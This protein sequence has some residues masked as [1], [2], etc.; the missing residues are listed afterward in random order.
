MLTTYD[1]P[2]MYGNQIST[3]DTLRTS[4]HAD[5]TLLE[6]FCGS[7]EV[8]RAFT[9]HGFTCFKVDK[10]KRAGKCVPDLCC[11]LLKLN[12]ALFPF[13]STSII[14]A[15]V[16]CDAFS[17]AAGN[18]YRDGTGYKESTKYFQKLLIKTL[19]I[20]EVMKPTW[21]FIENPRASLRYN[22]AMIDFLCRTS[23]TIKQ[24][25]LGSYNFPTT[26]PT[27]IFTNYSALKL[28]PMLPYGRGAKN[29]TGSFNNLTKCQ[30]QATPFLL[31]DS[32]AEQ[33]KTT[34][35]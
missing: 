4:N 5:L 32:I 10:R 6:L 2:P 7:A 3:V 27:D 11:D 8:S 35:V 19:S 9:F 20:I 33:I 17:N 26:K 23:G 29:V 18:Y 28:L 21:Y 15:S 1:H 14:W 34:L 12:T 22:K 25:T 31:A 24:C 30:R 16:P 13:K